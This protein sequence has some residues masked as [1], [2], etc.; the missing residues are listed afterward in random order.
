[1]LKL[2]AIVR[3]FG[4]YGLLSGFISAVVYAIGEHADKSVLTTCLVFIGAPIAQGAILMAYA[5]IGY[6][7]YRFAVRN[8]LLRRAAV[9][10]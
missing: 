8:G 4:L 1:M 3:L 10:D 9:D 5:A 6:P 2:S 7:V